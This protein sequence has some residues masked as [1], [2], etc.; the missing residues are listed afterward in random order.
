MEEFDKLIDAEEF[1]KAVLLL[2]PLVQ[3][4]NGRYERFR[5][6]VCHF[7]L[8]DYQ[9]ALAVLRPLTEEEGEYAR[10]AQMVSA[11]ALKSLKRWKQAA[12]AFERVLALGDKSASPDEERMVRVLMAACHEEDEDWRSALEIYQSI[13]LTGTE[14]D[15]ELLFRRALVH[16]ELREYSEAD[17]LYSEFLERFPGHPDAE[18]ALFKHAQTLYEL[19]RYERA[20]EEFAKVASIEPSTFLT[21]VAGELANKCRSAQAKVRQATRSYDPR[22]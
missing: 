20:E 8:G 11:H 17:R 15:D 22:H 2:D 4:G 1:E 12:A 14:A 16:Q 3:K 21:Q 18:R 7:R 10:E 6:G 5:L 9:E 19:G 13:A